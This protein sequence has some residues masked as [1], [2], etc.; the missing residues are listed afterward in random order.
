MTMLPPEL[1]Q[2]IFS[3]LSYPELYL[4]RGVSR[5]WQ[6][7]VASFLYWNIKTQHQVNVSIGARSWLGVALHAHH[8]DKAHHIV[9]FR[10]TEDQAILDTSTLTPTASWQVYHQRQL[11]ILFSGWKSASPALPR[12]YEHLAGTDQEL[13]H[14][15][16]DY[17]PS[18]ACLYALPPYD[19]SAHNHAGTRYVGDRA[20]ILAYSYVDPPHDPDHNDAELAANDASIPP[21]MTRR[22]QMTVLPTRTSTAP[23]IRI[24]WLRVTMDWVV[25]GHLPALMPAQIYADRYERLYHTLARHHGCFKYDELAEPVLAFIV[26]Q[27][28]RDEDKK[29]EPAWPLPVPSSAPPCFFAHPPTPPPDENDKDA[30]PASL[31]TY[32]QEHTHEYHTRLSKLGHRLAGVGVDARMIW[33]YPFAKSFVAGNG[34]LL[35]EED[36]VRRIQDAEIEWSRLRMRCLQRS[37][38][39][40]L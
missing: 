13:A 1:L 10:P 35:S 7:Q 4:L 8:Y 37:K 23:R 36:V 17:N 24:H 11:Q 19:W 15:H 20:M 30:V 2:H 34:S 18:L 27:E 38:A 25:A 26:E 5:S 16:L 33:K 14:F 32:L 3:Y 40:A 39:L 31:V 21:I 29:K 6:Q 22:A 28:D 12:A 9:E